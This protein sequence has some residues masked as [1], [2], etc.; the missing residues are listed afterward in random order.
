MSVLSAIVP[1]VTPPHDTP[2]GLRDDQGHTL[3]VGQWV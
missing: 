3:H 1:L 2:W